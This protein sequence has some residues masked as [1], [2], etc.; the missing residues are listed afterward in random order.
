MIEAV[1]DNIVKYI[2]TTD[3]IIAPLKRI[4][5]HSLTEEGIRSAVDTS[6]DL[7]EYV[8]LIF[9]ARCR[10]M[11]DWL[12]I[13]Y[14][15]FATM[16]YSNRIIRNDT[17]KIISLGRVQTP[18]LHLI[19]KR[20]YERENFKKE[21]YYTMDATMKA[22]NGMTFQA[23]YKIPKNEKIKDVNFLR[24]VA[25]QVN[26]ANGQIVSLIEETEYEKPFKLYNLNDL[27]IEASNL[28]GITSKDTAKAAQALYE[29]GIISYSRTNSRNLSTDMLTHVKEVLSTLP[30][31]YK[32]YIDQID[33]N[34]LSCD[35][36][37]VFEDT[38]ES[39]SAIIPTNV[40]HDF[41]YLKELPMEC[42]RI[43]G[44]IVRRFIGV[45]MKDTIYDKLS[46]QI[47]VAG[48]TFVSS[49][50]I[51]KFNG[52]KDLIKKIYV[53]NKDNN[54]DVTENGDENDDINL[55]SSEEISRDLLNYLRTNM[56]DDTKCVKINIKEKS[57]QKPPYYTEAKLLQT[58]E[59]ATKFVED[60]NLRE[61]LKNVGLGTVA[62]RAAIIERLINVGYIK[63]KG[64]KLISTD[65]GRK[66]IEILPID[67]LKNISMTVEW[68]DKLN[69]ICEGLY[70]PKDF[71][72][73][74]KQLTIANC[75]KIK[76]HNN[77]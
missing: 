22:S 49:K 28:Y 27:Q 24:E 57:T 7:T 70:S 21:L 8:N 2:S 63:R 51:L 59:S 71:I 34:K 41:N 77:I 52:Y 72:K 9:A 48:Y 15:V 33:Q 19:V 45:F 75:N 74:I 54:D 18:V 17:N 25:Q 36:N 60:E 69:K 5:I 42:Q 50:R 39:H 68:E 64:K 58:M 16:K 26:N 43:Y 40:K 76:M 1:F 6:K 38:E 10:A 14:T 44:L 20:D 67:S 13:N 62:T 3:K 56:N 53:S 66:L 35:Y 11:A 65:K 73:E 30:N 29:K 46:I 61:N 23:N 47:D 55:E 12:S 32:Q 4:W 37:R 31:F